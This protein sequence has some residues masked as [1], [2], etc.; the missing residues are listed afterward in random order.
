MPALDRV[1]FSYY[2]FKKDFPPMAI[3]TGSKDFTYKASKTMADI[4]TKYNRKKIMLIDIPNASHDFNIPERAA[5]F[6]KAYD[7]ISKK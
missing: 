1:P 2:D 4:L 5:A 3:I 7:F 6:T